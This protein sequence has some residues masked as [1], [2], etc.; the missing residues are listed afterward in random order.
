MNITL[1]IPADWLRDVHTQYALLAHEE[2]TVRRM[3][4]ELLGTAVSRHTSQDAAMPW[5]AAPAV[6]EFTSGDKVRVMAYIPD[7]TAR[8]MAG[9]ARQRQTTP[10]E[11]AKSL[12]YAL[13]LD[14]P[15]A[16]RLVTAHS[17]PMTALLAHMPGKEARPEQVAAFSCM[18][19][20]LSKGRIGMVEA[21]TG[22]GKALAAMLA[23]V[24]WTQSHASPVVIATPTLALVR[25][26]VAEY[27]SIASAGAH[28]V[29]DGGQKNGEATPTEPTPIG[30]V[31]EP[32]PACRAIFGRRE[33]I[34]E[35]ALRNLID[36][37]PE[38]ATASVDAWM[39]RGGRDAKSQNSMD[40]VE[41]AWLSDSLLS[42]EPDMPVNEVQLGEIVAADDAGLQ[43]YRGQFEGAIA[44]P[45]VGRKLIL[46]CTHSM[47]A[48]DMRIRLRRAS[49]DPDFVTINKD[50]FE[51]LKSM[52]GTKRAKGRGHSE[53]S[54]NETLDVQRASLDAAR[55]AL[56]EAFASD[57]IVG[58]LPS[59][60]ALIVDEAHQLEQS[61]SNAFSEYL[62]MQ[63]LLRQL[64]EYKKLGGTVPGPVIDAVSSAI[65]GLSRCVPK[66]RSNASQ[67]MPLSAT[68]MLSAR[69]RLSECMDALAPIAD[70]KVTLSTPVERAALLMHI[71]RAVSLLRLAL[72]DGLGRS[73]LR[74]SPTRAYPQI[75]IG[76][77]SV[78]SILRLLWSSVQC[79]VALSATLY[80]YRSDGPTSEY[81]GGLLCIPNEKLAV[82]PPIE[83]GWLM[84]PIAK[85]DIPEGDRAVRLRPPSRLDRL[86]PAEH[87]RR[88]ELWLDHLAQEIRTI[89]SSSVGGVLVLNTSYDM[90]KGLS[91]RLTNERM[92]VPTVGEVDP[93]DEDEGHD[94]VLPAH[95]WIV[96]A[97]EGV[98]IAKQSTAFL[99]ISSRGLKPL[100]LAVGGAWT[101]L[102]IGGHEPFKRL[103]GLPMLPAD[104]DQ[105]LTDLVVPR[106]PF[107]T[108]NSITHMRRI[109]M[110]PAMPWDM[111]D[112]AF[113]FRQALGRIVRR[114]GLSTNRRIFILD[115]RLAEPGAKGRLAIFWNVIGRLQARIDRR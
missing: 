60:G 38:F 82:Y 20:A 24:R 6:G 30:V 62:P 16:A 88:T 58:L 31:Q 64:F 26:L 45:E 44:H 63:K 59:Y 110:R 56:Y 29:G 19:D 113:R 92:A 27:R 35:S 53:D 22:V 39:R 33:F 25:Q 12:L 103:L 5:R 36:S 11:V 81:M 101:G 52:R 102:D 95:P 74:L 108:N 66:N 100:W 51:I 1:T 114:M 83:A 79:G 21:S 99:S 32:I 37:K 13:W 87:Q 40:R 96:T 15:A 67:M 2:S 90:V 93:E 41:P 105:V 3:V 18:E 77:S 78:E 109:A 111:L 10:A 34:S 4:V 115:G 104:I 70:R 47:L 75:H 73:Y 112:A 97:Q 9:I 71:K 65:R 14:R 91:K 72:N 68:D 46:I 94:D 57:T 80:L 85:V 84:D 23:A 69:L 89:H 49:R 61:F 7:V 76:Q 8:A 17:S 54:H 98:S 107:G 43:A 106:L 50:I 86:D 28:A 48:Q 55:S 42:V